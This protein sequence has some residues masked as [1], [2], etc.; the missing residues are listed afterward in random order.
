VPSPVSENGQAS[1]PRVSD[2]V[3]T[4]GI[5]APPRRPVIVPLNTKPVPHSAEN[6]PEAS[7]AVWFVID[8]VK[9]EQLEKS[10]TVT[11]DAVT[12]GVDVPC[13]TQVPRSEGADDFAGVAPEVVVGPSTVDLRSALHADVAAIATTSELNRRRDLFCMG[14]YLL[15]SDNG[16]SADT[17]PFTR[18]SLDPQFQWDK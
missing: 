2:P 7:V 11:E 4:M 17:S 1:E 16:Q 6:R 13:T 15:V 3:T 18:S 5:V 10:G 14:G 8:Q 12:A 9:F